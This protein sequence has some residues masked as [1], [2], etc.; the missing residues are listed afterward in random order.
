MKADRKTH[1]LG[2]KHTKKNTQKKLKN[3]SGS[4]TSDEGLM[5][6]NS[7]GVWEV[8]VKMQEEG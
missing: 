8:R 2:P 6:A 4:T 1:L 7:K 5:A 3:C